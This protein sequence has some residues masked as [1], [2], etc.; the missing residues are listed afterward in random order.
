MLFC[1]RLHAGLPGSTDTEVL[2]KLLFLLHLE[3]IHHQRECGLKTAAPTQPVSGEA[4]PEHEANG[5]PLPA[6]Q[7][8]GSLLWGLP[9]DWLGCQL[10][11]GEHLGQLFT[12]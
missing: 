11:P 6:P 1:E 3:A 2:W 5:Q 7:E 8:E 10:A 4:L 12:A 9:T